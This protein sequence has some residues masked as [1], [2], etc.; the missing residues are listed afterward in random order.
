MELS[1]DPGS[2]WYRYDF[3]T[4]PP[5]SARGGDTCYLFSGSGPLEVTL[6]TADG[7]EITLSGAFDQNRGTAAGAETDGHLGNATFEFLNQFRLEEDHMDENCINKPI[8]HFITSG[9][10]VVVG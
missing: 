5:A 8:K 3:A 1:G 10:G 6:P 4:R 9:Q 7:G 2:I